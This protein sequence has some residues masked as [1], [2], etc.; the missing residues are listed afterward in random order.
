MVQSRVKMLAKQQPMEKLNRI[1]TLEF[2]FNSAPFTA[3]VLMKAENLSFAYE[4]NQRIFD[5]FDIEVRAH[6]RIC[7]MGQ[8]GKGKSTLLRLLA[9]DLKPQAGKIIRHAKLQTGFF[10]QTNVHTLHPG[11]TVVG[12]IM[13]AD[14]GCLPQTA[15]NIA[16]SMMF[17]GD[18]GM[19]EISVLSGGEKSRVM[20]GKIL[21]APCN[22]LLLDEP[23]NHLDLDSCDSLL[24]AI[25]AFDGAV[26]IV[27]HNEM[28]L[29]S[30]A[31]RFI[32]F[33]RGRI[34][35]YARSYQDFLAD[36]GWELDETLRQKDAS[37]NDAKPTPTLDKKALRQAR[38]R[39]VQERSR[40]VGPL[41]KRVKELEATIERFEAETADVIAAM[42]AASLAGDGEALGEHS[43]RHE[44][45][46]TDIDAAS[47]ASR[48]S[49]NGS[50]LFRPLLRTPYTTA[51]VDL[52]I[53]LEESLTD[54]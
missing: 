50:F 10:A 12:E 35:D 24:A 39:I 44:Q 54:D 21:V 5:G 51:H 8:N 28:F 17:E 3:K 4:P 18:D 11:H 40:I 14:K 23:T 38:A 15:R 36:I 25:D 7:V 27:T 46:K 53:C 29:R 45:L 19:K 1:K 43:R 22:L 41:E 48:D 32:V 13:S 49:A 31:N 16:G 26:V 2:S 30:L 47:F 34:T 42:E 6:D 37:T 9:G 33:D 20:L 52:E